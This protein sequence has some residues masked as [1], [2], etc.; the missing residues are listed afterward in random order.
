MQNAQHRFLAPQQGVGVR[1]V[2]GSVGILTRDKLP[3]GLHPTASYFWR[4]PIIL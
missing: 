3:F 1:L 4:V 2:C